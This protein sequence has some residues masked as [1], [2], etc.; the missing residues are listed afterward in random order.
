MRK[1]KQDRESCWHNNLKGSIC[2]IFTSTYSV[3]LYCLYFFCLT[4]YMVVLICLSYSILVQI[5][6]IFHQEWCRNFLEVL[7]GEINYQYCI[8]QLMKRDYKVRSMCYI[9]LIVFKY[10]H[11]LQFRVLYTVILTL[12]VQQC[13]YCKGMDDVVTNDINKVANRAERLVVVAKVTCY[14][15]TPFKVCVLFILLTV[16]CLVTYYTEELYQK[17]KSIFKS[18]QSS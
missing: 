15:W 18:K 17:I 10:P 6:H 2:L 3:V 16:E 14:P 7:I 11:H 4:H 5:L 12:P 8:H 1:I 9:N 13:S